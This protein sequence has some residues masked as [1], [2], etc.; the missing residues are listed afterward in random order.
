MGKGDDLKLT[1]KL[2]FIEVRKDEN[3][4]AIDFLDNNCARKFVDWAMEV[5]FHEEKS[6][7]NGDLIECWDTS[8]DFQEDF[9]SNATD[10][11]NLVHKIF[12]REKKKKE[13]L[14]NAGKNLGSSHEHDNRIIMDFIERLENNESNACHDFFP[15]D[16]NVLPKIL[17][18]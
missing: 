18:S 17:R 10:K 14:K 15:K 12:N 16:L 4:L 6:S 11:T 13:G 8:E 2:N 9:K 1:N 7:K 5:D 3:P